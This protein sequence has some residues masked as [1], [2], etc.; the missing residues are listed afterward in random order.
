MRHQQLLEAAQTG[1]AEALGELLEDYRAYLSVLASRYLDSRLRGRLD[2]ADVVQITFLEAQRD[3]PNFRGQ[4]IE[5]LLGWLRHILRNN[6][7]SAHQRHLYT[8]KRSAGREVSN[9]PT[10]SRPAFTDL[11]P[12]ETTSPSQRM[13]RDEAGV[14]LANCLE[15]LP[16]TQREA[17]RLRYV[18]GQ[19]LKQIAEAMDKSEMAVAGLLKRGLAALR[20]QMLTDSSS[21]TQP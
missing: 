19:S 18:E 2:P 7:S 6:V 9:N 8:Q 15:Q 5:E 20:Q 11:A 10:D 21:G 16:E 3:L 12:A 1:D 14:Y 17:L 4:H 13:M